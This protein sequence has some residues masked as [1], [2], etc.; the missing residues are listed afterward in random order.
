M[1]LIERTRHI[2]VGSARQQRHFLQTLRFLSSELQVAL[3]RAGIQEARFAL[4]ADP[5]VRNQ[6]AE[7]VL[8]P[9]EAGL[10]LRLS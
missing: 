6:F 10:T 4:L 5:Q 3:V 1:G 2:L 8:Q 9:R 7:V